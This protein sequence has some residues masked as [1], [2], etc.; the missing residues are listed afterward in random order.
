[1]RRI[2]LGLQVPLHLGVLCL[3]VCLIGGIRAPALWAQGDL[4]EGRHFFAIE[5][6]STG[7]ID[8]RG[9]TGTLGIAFSNL[10]LMA[11][12]DYRVWV[13]NAATLE[14]GRVDITTGRPGT[15]IELPELALRPHS[16]LDADKDGLPDVAEFIVGTD[17]QNPDSDNDGIL[18]GAEVEQGGDPTDGVPVAT[19]VLASVNMPGPAVDLSVMDDLLLVA[20]ENGVTAMTVFTGLNP[21]IVGTLATPGTATRVAAS[22]RSVAVA[23]G[24]AGLL[25]VDFSSP[26]MVSIE[27]QLPPIV[28]P[29]TGLGIG[30]A[31]C[32][33]AAANFAYVGLSNGLVVAVDTVSGFA[34][35]SVDLGEAVNDLG[36]EG[37]TLYA[38]TT[39]TIHAMPLDPTNLVVS[40]SANS[41]VSTSFSRLFVGGGIAYG[42]HNRG[43][44]SFSL[45]TPAQPTLL[46][47]TSTTSLG[48]RDLAVNGSGLGLAAV[49]TS[50]GNENISLYDVADIASANNNLSDRFLTELMTAGNAR[51]VEIANGVAYVADEGGG[52]LVLNYLQA[53]TLGVAPT[54]ALSGSFDL[55]TAEEGKRVRIS[56]GVN[57]DIAMRSVEFLIDGD[58]VTDPT[59]PFEQHF[60]T[61]LLVDQPSFTLRARAFDTGGN[62]TFTDEIVV[63][64]TP[65]VS[66][67]V[68]VN[69]LPN[70]GVVAPLD[71]VVALISEPLDASTLTTSTF[72][73]TSA[74]TDG[75]LGTGD[76][77]PVVLDSV[78]FRGD[79]LGAV[80]NLSAGFA[81]NIYRARLD[82]SI[83]DLSG[84]ALATDQAWTFVVYPNTDV[85]MNGI[86]DGL[87]DFDGDGLINAYEAILGLDPNVMD[88]DSMSDSDMD[89]VLDVI[90]LALGS[91]PLEV[92]TDG[93]GFSDGDEVALNSDPVDPNSIPI[94]VTFSVFSLENDGGLMDGIEI[95]SV[96]NDGG[97]PQAIGVI[98]ISNDAAP[99][100][101]SGEIV[102]K[103][104]SVENVG[105]P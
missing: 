62:F 89:G 57:D 87:E 73:I 50:F 72:T 12:T 48:W 31:L 74:G 19:G 105:N 18:D 4:I 2:A 53:D 21:A 47:N 94:S 67:P 61:P 80:A 98:S 93:D 76:D 59:F 17:I 38:V 97:I 40:G 75:I 58:S 24:S 26:P 81:P 37:D 52:L 11:R 23:A 102:P 82:G 7:N 8:Q 68:V 43:F 86:P 3:G 30:D 10:V 64:L 95:F 9:T 55:V 25:I 83:T 14:I 22:T 35:S 6:Q 16:P 44:N 65:D 49:G 90:E 85:D 66:Q 60:V 15:R 63:T 5:N 96:A 91:D 103:V 92:D 51:A 79:I 100:A 33:A 13:L 78:E 46:K 39:N 20:H 71:S 27:H 29:V 104:V 84:N 88:F 56:A 41:S 69:V 101:I 28:L 42:V 70:G 34:L 54:I 36:I 32:V 1:M 77:Q 45:A 99:E